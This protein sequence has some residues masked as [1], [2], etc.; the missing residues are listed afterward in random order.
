M[1]IR[2]LPY[3]IDENASRFEFYETF[4]K[5]QGLNLLLKY[6]RPQG[7][8]LLDYGCGRG[9]CLGMAIE[10]GF[11]VRGTDMDTECVVLASHFGPACQLDIRNPL[12]QFGAKSFDVV[13]CFHVLEHVDNPKEV[14]TALGKI[15]RTHVVIA[16]PNLRHLHRLFVRQ[17]DLANFNEGHLQSWDHWHLLNLAEK[18]CGL[19]LVAWGF[20]ATILPMASN[21]SE[22]VFGQKAT[23]WLETA[24]FRR[25]FPYHGI[26]VLGLFQPVDLNQEHSD[27]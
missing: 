18:H 6:C 15:A 17:I 10:A 13:T 5:R 3:H 27:S 1:S 11:A 23:I 4:W 7:K 8:T 24:I 20:D 22:K 26:S 19:K 12:A 16:V 9:E 25:M 21:L 2:H 14:L